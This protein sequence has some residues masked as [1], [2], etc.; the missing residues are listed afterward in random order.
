MVDHQWSTRMCACVRACVRACA[1][2][3]INT[4]P[5]RGPSVF[6][7]LCYFDALSEIGNLPLDIRSIR[8]VR[9]HR[10]LFVL[11]A[12]GSMYR[13]MRENILPPT[14]STRRDIGFSLDAI[15]HRQSVFPSVFLSEYTRNIRLIS[16]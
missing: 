6:L 1:R 13:T 12:L 14:V 15:E 4:S 3:Y 7:T 16:T 9:S 8:I 10:V 5:L 2:V 11:A